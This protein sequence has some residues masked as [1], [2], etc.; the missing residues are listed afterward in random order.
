MKNKDAEYTKRQEGGATVF[1]VT[2]APAPKFTYLLIFGVVARQG[3][4]THA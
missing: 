1:E 3:R 4:M 2:P